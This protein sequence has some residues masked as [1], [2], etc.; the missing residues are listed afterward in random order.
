M[1]RSLMVLLLTISP[2]ALPAQEGAFTLRQYLAEAETALPGLAGARSAEAG[3]TLLRD[4]GQAEVS[5][6]FF[7]QAD[8]SGD[9]SGQLLP[10][11]QGDYA[12]AASVSAGAALKT[13]GGFEGRAYYSFGRDIFHGSALGNVDQWKTSQNLELSAAL[14]RNRKGLETAS[15]IDS[16]RALRDAR[17][18]EA[19]AEA[20]LLRARAEQA[21]WRLAAIKESIEIS[22][23]SLR[24][25]R[26]LLAWSRAL[27]EAG[28]ADASEALGAEASAK[29]REQEL[30]EKT[31][32]LRQA[33]RRFNTFLG[34]NSGETPGSMEKVDGPS[35]KPAAGVRRD[36]LA[37]ELQARSAELAA[38]GSAEST[39]PALDLVTKLSLNGFGDQAGGAARGAFSTGGAAA[40]AGLRLNMPFSG[41]LTRDNRRG[42]ELLA[43]A[44]RLKYRQALLESEAELSS[45]SDLFDALHG[46]LALAREVETAQETKYRAERARREKGKTTVYFMLAYQDDYAAA[47]ERRVAVALELRLLGAELGLF[48][49]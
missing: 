8:L 48:S 16:A 31:G 4:E 42:Y 10:G 17:A 40:S 24:N 25:A 9:N 19:R 33:A 37:A 5:P 35:V 21:Y 30:L 12:K 7:A 27:A 15:G 32:S 13:R 49:R 44:A 6:R 22:S 23:G 18:E 14:W 43:K 20:A 36:V 45:Q 1:K 47:R 41:S 26:E 46:Q 28:L 3:E 2:L 29:M 38:A 39:K 11:L 34:R